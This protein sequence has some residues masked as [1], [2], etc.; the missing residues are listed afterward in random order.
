MPELTITVHHEAGLHARPLSQF[1]KNARKFEADVQ[2]SNLSSGKGPVD[3]KSPLKLLLLAVLQSHDI[4]I[5][6]TGADADLALESLRTLIESNFI[7]KGA[8]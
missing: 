4:K 8:E 1:V 7:D 2:V 6:C 3:G 5:E